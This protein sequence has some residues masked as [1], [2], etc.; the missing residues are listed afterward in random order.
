MGYFERFPYTNIHEMNLDW[1]LNAMKELSEEFRTFADTNKINYADPFNWDIARSYGPMTLVKDP[2]TYR[3]YMSRVPVPAGV[4]LS[5]PAYWLEVGDMSAYGHMI[6]TINGDIDDINTALDG[7]RTDITEVTDILTD[8]EYTVKYPAR[9]FSKSYAVCFGDSNTMPNPPDGYGNTFEYICSYIPFKGHKSYGISGAA[10]QAGV[11]S[12]PQIVNQVPGAN[13]YPTTQVGFVFLMGGANDW[14]YARNNAAFGSA[15]DATLTAIRAKFP[16]A[17]IIS[18]FDA[19]HMW[20]SDDLFLFQDT[21]SRRCS[22]KQNCAFVSVTDLCLYDSAWAPNSNSYKT[23]ERVHYSGTGANAIAARVLAGLYGNSLGFTVVP[24]RTV[25]H[26]TQT[27]P[28][29]GGAYNFW[30]LT[31]TIIDPI[32]LYRIDKTRIFLD[33]NFNY[34][35]GDANPLCLVPGRLPGSNAG[36]G[37]LARYVNITIFNAS[38][39]NAAC[40]VTGVANVNVAA[41]KQYPDSQ[42]YTECGPMIQVNMLHP[43]N[44]LTSGMRGMIEFTGII[45]GRETTI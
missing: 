30:T 24:R 1:L 41:S 4:Q 29:P 25:K 31:D 34:G 26:Y 6:D 16:N 42:D 19:C 22:Q 23:A 7:V 13:D 3:V 39:S 35:D 36:P 45:T 44:W 33:S 9:D 32:T 43:E 17:L 21:M 18:V 11:S 28:G 20:P 27:S 8:W 37:A 15:V 12:G 38:N 40:A 5:D 10:F 14:N 2:D